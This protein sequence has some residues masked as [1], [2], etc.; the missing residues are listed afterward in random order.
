MPAV[1]FALVSYVGWATGDIFGTIATRKIGSYLTN[2]YIYLLVTI[3]FAF[4]IPF[5]FQEL[6]KFSFN[7]LF[8]NLFLGVIFTIATFLVLEALRIGNSS[9]IATIS[10]SYAWIVVIFSLIFFNEKVDITQIIS[11]LVILSGLVLSTVNFKD[12]KANIL[13]DRSIRLAFLA[14]ALF[15]IYF[16]FIKIP[17][18]EVGWFWPSYITDIVGLI[19][20][21][22]YGLRKFNFSKKHLS[23]IGAIAISDVLVGTGNFSYNYAVSIGASSIIAPIAGSSLTLYV[24]LSF[25]VF[26]DKIT[27]QQVLGIVTT[28]V[29]IVLLSFFSV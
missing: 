22:F 24:L 14:L 9:L 3:L 23:S 19:I 26:K 10:W 27:K 1:F 18:K 28:L 16:T 25:L 5:S 21:I 15:G 11:I 2:F 6:T 12:L 7:I 8:L 20:M 13:N 29:G 17:S 4:Y